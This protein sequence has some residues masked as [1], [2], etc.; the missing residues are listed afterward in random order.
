MHSLGQHC[1]KKTVPNG[2][3]LSHRNKGYFSGEKTYKLDQRMEKNMIPIMEMTYG[4]TNWD[5][6]NLEIIWIAQTQGTILHPTT[7]R[8]S[9]TI[10]NMHVNIIEQPQGV[11]YPLEKKTIV[12]ISM[13][14]IMG[15][16]H[17]FLSDSKESKV[18]RT[19]DEIDL[20]RA[21]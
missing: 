11:G 17:E 1:L 16:H 15:R 14:L 7:P 4:V 13:I 21:T 10:D 2:R 9:R 19:H 18:I 6:G 5:L 12:T 3:L 8:S 20:V